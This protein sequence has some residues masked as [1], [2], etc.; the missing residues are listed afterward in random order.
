MVNH[1]VNA[2]KSMCTRALWLH[3]GRLIA[4]DNPEEVAK[5]YTQWTGLLSSG[6]TQEANDFLL[7]IAR[8][9][10]PID[11]KTS[12]EEPKRLPR[13]FVQDT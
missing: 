3:K 7:D 12:F 8:S 11:L 5:N 1:N 6:K 9:F 2:L 13:H 4:D 10:V